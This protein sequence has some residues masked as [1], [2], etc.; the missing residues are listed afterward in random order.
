MTVGPAMSLDCYTSILSPG[1][2]PPGCWNAS[3]RRPPV[4]PKMYEAVAPGS[5]ARMSRPL[6]V[7]YGAHGRFCRT[8]RSTGSSLRVKPAPA[9]RLG[10]YRPAWGIVCGSP[11][12]GSFQVRIASR[13]CRPGRT[14]HNWGRP[15]LSGAPEDR[16][17]NPRRCRLGIA[18]LARGARPP[19]ARTAL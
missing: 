9:A 7:E 12:D 11:A 1:V 2:P 17:S 3:F 19:N 13:P 8:G 16:R 18:R 10:S 14:S 6:I 4:R 15:G 5:A